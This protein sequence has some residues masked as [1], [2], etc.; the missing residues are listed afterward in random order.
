MEFPL[1][2][3]NFTAFAL[4]V[5]ALELLDEGLQFVEMVHPVIG[6]SQRADLAGLLGFD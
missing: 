4:T 2:N 3:T 5:L 1:A 6:D